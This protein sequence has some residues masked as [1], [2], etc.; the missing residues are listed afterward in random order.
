MICYFILVASQLSREA[1]S[2]CNHRRE[3]V[4]DAPGKEGR[5][6]G[7]RKVAQTA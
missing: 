4:V 3:P 2:A 1:A 5:A 6:C 7:H